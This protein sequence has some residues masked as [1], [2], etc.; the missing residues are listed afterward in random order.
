[1]PKLRKKNVELPDDVKD[2]FQIL[3]EYDLGVRDA[4]MHLLRQGGWTLQSIADAVGD[5]SRERVRQCVNEIS[6]RTAR[7]RVLKARNADKRLTLPVPPL[8]E[9]P[10]KVRTPKKIVDP[11]PETLARLKELEP[12]AKQ[13][14]YDHSANRK[15]AEEYM[16]LVWKAHTVEGVSL[17]RLS[18]LLGHKSFPLN[19]RLV[20]YGYKPTEGSSKSLAPVKYRK[21]K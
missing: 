13:V 8:P 4:Y 19:S 2:Q 3:T 11:K 15:E 17:Y 6:T 10:E 7:N 1:M 9:L 12:F 16:A 14:R 18:K 21:R 5:I 20:R